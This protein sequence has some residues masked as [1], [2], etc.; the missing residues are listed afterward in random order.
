MTDVGKLLVRLSVGLMAFHGVD[1]LHHGLAFIHQALAA[2]GL[3]AFVAYG[4][5]L[6]ELVAPV[7]VLVGFLARPAGVLVSFTMLFAIWLVH[8]DQLFS[9]NEFGGV[10][11]ELNWMYVLAGLAVACLGSGRYSLSRGRGKWD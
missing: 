8:T 1:K 5:Y 10:A 4:V 11:L 7:L 2:K 6:G 3:P 9:L